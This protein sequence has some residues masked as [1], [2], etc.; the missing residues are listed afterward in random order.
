MDV[1][2]RQGSKKTQEEEEGFTLRNHTI[3]SLEALAIGMC[4]V[5]HCED[6]LMCLVY[7]CG[8]LKDTLDSNPF[9]VDSLYAE[10]IF[11]K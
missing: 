9:H 8:Y 3:V 6:I 11:F 5:Q 4:R 10:P 1:P 7:L 2:D